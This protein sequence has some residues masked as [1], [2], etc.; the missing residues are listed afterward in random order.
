MHYRKLLFRD[1]RL[2]QNFQEVKSEAENAYGTIFVCPYLTMPSSW[3][4]RSELVKLSFGRLPLLLYCL[5][6]LYNLRGP[7]SIYSP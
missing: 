5:E 2:H 7:N 1:E 6:W 4:L 3:G